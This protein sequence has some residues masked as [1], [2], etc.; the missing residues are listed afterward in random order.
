MVLLFLIHG[1]GVYKSI[2][3]HYSSYKHFDS[4]NFIIIFIF[5]THTHHVI[6]KNKKL[7][8]YF[9]SIF[10][11]LLSFPVLLFFCMCDVIQY[12]IQVGKIKHDCQSFWMRFLIN[13]N[14]TTTWYT[15]ITII[16]K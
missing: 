9:S 3:Y 4:N 14:T 8:Y 1:L 7:F 10:R 6:N 13:K 11:L 15:R 2:H 16:I 12:E 5:C